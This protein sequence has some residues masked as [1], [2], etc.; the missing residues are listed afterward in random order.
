M[1]EPTKRKKWSDVRAR[2]KAFDRKG[3]V[4]LLGDDRPY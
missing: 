1:A 2:L 3:V 4:S